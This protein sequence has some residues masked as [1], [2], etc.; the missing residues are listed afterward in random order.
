M[1]VKKELD[2]IASSFLNE[3]N[4][5]KMKELKSEFLKVLTR[6]CNMDSKLVIT[7]IN[8]WVADIDQA[9]LDI[10]ENREIDKKFLAMSFIGLINL[11]DIP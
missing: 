1:T 2:N 5:N 8:T 10:S 11:V 3:T 6:S 4:S 7:A 9:I